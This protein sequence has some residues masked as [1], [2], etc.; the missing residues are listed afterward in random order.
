MDDGF[1]GSLQRE[2][3]YF[4]H[5][6]VMDVKA[7]FLLFIAVAYGYNVDKLFQIAFSSNK[8]DSY[9]GYTVN[10]YHEPVN[11][12]S[13]L[14]AG[15]PR[16]NYTEKRLEHII[17]PGVVF[18]C[19]VEDYE[20][21]EIQLKVKEN[22]LPYSLRQRKAIV[23]KN[24]G[25]FGAA[26]SIERS[27]GVLTVCAP[28]TSVRI[29]NTGSNPF[30]N[31]RGVCYNGKISS[32]LS[33]EDENIDLTYLE[34]YETNGFSI[35]YASMRNEDKGKK[36]I[37]RIVGNPAFQL[38][39][40]VNI[41]H[42]NKL[43]S[44]V[45]SGGQGVKY[46][47]YS[48]ETGYFFR[49]NQLLY[50]GGAPN[51]K[52]VGLVEVIGVERYSTDAT[53]LRGT[54]TGEFFGGSLAVGDLNND[55]LD[56]LLVGAPN[57]GQD[58]GKV[59]VYL[60]TSKV[61]TPNDTKCY[62]INANVFHVSRKGQFETVAPLQ[63][64]ANGGH[65]GYAIASGDLDADGFDDIIVG[66][67]WEES[68]AIYIYNGGP[69]LKHNKLQVSE[70][71]DGISLSNSI[72]PVKIQTFGFSLS[73][74][75]DID[76][77]GYPDIPVGAYKSGHAIVLLSKLVVKTEL[78]IR[79][80]PDALD[81]NA[82]KFVIEICPRYY[83][84]NIKNVQD[85]E[86]KITIT[87]D[88]QYR[89]TKETFLELRSPNLT[90]FKCL[91]A[92]VKI[93]KNIR[94]FIEP[95]SIF[96]KHD[97]VYSKASSGRFCKFCPVERKDNKLN[98]A[99]ILLPFNIGCG[100]DKVCHSNISVSAK[101]H[102]TRGDNTW[103][104]GSTGISLE[105]NLKNYGEPAYLT[106][107]E[108]TLP[109]GVLLDSILP[110]CQ[111]DTSKENLIIVC[112]AGNPLWKEEK[113]ITLD[114]DM[115][116]LIRG[117]LHEH[118]LN[119]DIVIKTRSMNQG[120][121]NI[122]KTLDLANEVSLSLNGKA[123]D[124]MYYVS[125]MNNN[126]S[127]VSFQ[128]TYQVYKLGVTPIEDARLVVKVPTVIE[129]SKPLV[130]VYKP[131]L[132]VSGEGFEC[133][134]EDALLDSQLVEIKEK[135]S[136]DDDTD[137]DRMIQKRDINEK[138]IEFYNI[139]TTEILQTKNDNLTADILYM[140]C[141]N[142][143][144]NCTIIE[145]NL[146]AL[147]TFQDVGKLTIKLLLNVERLKDISV[148][149]KV[150]LYFGTEAS[151]EIIKPAVS[152]PINGT[153]STMEILTI[154]YNNFETEELQLWI[155]LVSVFVGLL[156]LIIFVV[157]LSKLGFFKRKRKEDYLLNS[158]QKINEKRKGS[159]AKNDDE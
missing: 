120:T 97:F 72:Y 69:D 88:E 67:P 27:N 112:E 4:E 89:R 73:K 64:A 52:H 48:V 62:I 121:L 5:T 38:T 13:W 65:F 156:L 116:H 79:A 108:F 127:N 24:H 1:R 99:Q 131:Q 100:T 61:R 23:M 119:F 134:S 90:L 87:V 150:V 12:T 101:F 18:R 71:I 153:R 113:T 37:G 80:V 47:G 139:E 26:L 46:F 51:W 25:W 2:K 82:K 105:V 36:K 45:L 41:I 135:P 110:S 118:K 66:A 54:D 109:K 91:Q 31:M 103:I 83:G 49:K 76:G 114:L 29:L 58:N 59:Y 122:T 44:L 154:F 143:D 43:T 22:E 3:K 19:N 57:W 56:D 111:E 74:P 7:I 115:K 130:H 81:R 17:E 107:L 85:T 84:H 34:S 21:T 144:E 124:E 20:C 15:A 40:K 158:E 146:N 33:I 10:L 35:S 126:A 28:R 39:G 117:S 151:V 6:N 129:H 136:L 141:S 102:G 142:T 70:R 78:V 9:F 149:N 42:S 32:P 140:N 86:S 94:D 68:G 77:N 155:I 148:N 50:V 147:Q 93:L 95:I 157:I 106:T 92:T 75:I 8:N 138:N 55:G 96:A 98:V 104:I 133:F 60:G 125:A 152:L 159:T 145:C 137:G 63:G 128:H 16:A 53:E 123:N 132:Y 30:I 11:N 14:I